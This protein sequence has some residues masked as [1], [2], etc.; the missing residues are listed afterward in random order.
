MYSIDHIG[1]V[2]KDIEKSAEFYQNAFGC[3][4]A[5]RV[6]NERLKFVY[7]DANGQTIELLQYLIDDAERGR[8][9]V[10]HIAFRVD[11]IEEAIT[12]INKIGAKQEFDSPRIVGDKKIMFYEG[13]DRERIELVQVIRD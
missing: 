7:L 13:P 5:S 2:V 10:D 8:G 3:K 9:I 11:N 6:E 4:I 12:R 1:I